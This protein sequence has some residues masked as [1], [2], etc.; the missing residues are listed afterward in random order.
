M[1]YYSFWGQRNIKPRKVQNALGCTY[2]Q[3]SCFCAAKP[4]VLFVVSDKQL[5]AI[6]SDGNNLYVMTRKVVKGFYCDDRKTSQEIHIL[7]I[8]SPAMGRYIF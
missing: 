6:M 1:Q 5:Y 2:V 4:Q 8:V 7:L 3:P